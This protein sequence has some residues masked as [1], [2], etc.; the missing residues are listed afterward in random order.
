MGSA[1][2]VLGVSSVVGLV[3]FV[4]GWIFGRSHSSEETLMLTDQL[5]H[6]AELAESRRDQIEAVQSKI[7]Q[8]AA[9][10]KETSFVERIFR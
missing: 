6:L 7:D 2:V 10:K 3:S 1:L 9:T 5:Q 4:A 8:A